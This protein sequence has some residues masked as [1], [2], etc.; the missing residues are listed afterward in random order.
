LG[1]IRKELEMI[2]KGTNKGKKNF[3]NNLGGKKRN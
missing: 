2:E 1:K 3:K